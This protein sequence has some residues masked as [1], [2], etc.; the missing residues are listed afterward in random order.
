MTNEPRERRG[1]SLCNRMFLEFYFLYAVTT[2]FRFT[3]GRADNRRTNQNHLH[4]EN[5]RSLATRQAQGTYQSSFAA[6]IRVLWES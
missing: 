4:D 1:F 3:V 2:V 6:Q 5:V